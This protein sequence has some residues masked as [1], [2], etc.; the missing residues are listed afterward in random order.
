MWEMFKPAV[1][2]VTPA[3]FTTKD[4][5]AFDN[6]RTQPAPAD[7]FDVFAT[8]GEIAGELATEVIAAQGTAEPEPATPDTEPATVPE[9][10]E[11]AE[12]PDEASP[13]IPAGWA[14]V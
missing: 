1:A 4:P 13:V 7:P 12:A 9:P 11:P 6:T 2:I 5:A 3:Q 10:T 14:Y 8:L